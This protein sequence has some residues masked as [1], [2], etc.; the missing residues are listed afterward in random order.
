MTKLTEAGRNLAA[1]SRNKAFDPDFVVPYAYRPFDIRY[2]YYDPDVWT[3]AVRPLKACIDG[4]PIL[5]A[6]KIIK[7][8]SFSHVFTSRLFTDVIFCQTQAR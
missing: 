8:P 3:R 5:L 2:T 7:D 6:T 1:R 4:S